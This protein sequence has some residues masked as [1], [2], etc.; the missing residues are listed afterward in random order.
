MKRIAISNGHS[1]TTLAH[2]L[3]QPLYALQLREKDSNARALHSLACA[4]LALPRPHN[5]FVLINSRFDVALA[6][7]AHGLHLP[8]HS[9]S[10]SLFR[11]H[12]PPGFLISVS[13][14]NLA[15]LQQAQDA[16]YAFLSPIFPSPSKPGYGPPLGL[17]LLQQACAA[18]RIPVFALG[19][20]NES[21]APTC[22]SAGAAG[23]AS[24][25]A[26]GTGH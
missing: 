5:T 4:V 19:G 3:Q 13:C 7:G 6:A 20:V 14:H 1:L 18:S 10:P 12:A 15:E 25:S 24:I 17:P 11:P 8:A 26:F 23:Y 16:D 2:W 22:L 9:P 21:N